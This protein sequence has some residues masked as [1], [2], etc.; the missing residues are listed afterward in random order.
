MAEQTPVANKVRCLW[1]LGRCR[2]AKPSTFRFR[3]LL[4]IA[5]RSRASV[6]TT[7]NTTKSMI[8]AKLLHQTFGCGISRD[9]GPNV[10]CATLVSTADARGGR[11]PRL[12]TA[13]WMRSPGR[14][15]GRGP[16][17]WGSGLGPGR[18]CRPARRRPRW[19]RDVKRGERRDHAQAQDPRGG[20]LPALRAQRF[21]WP[22]RW[23]FLHRLAVSVLHLPGRGRRPVRRA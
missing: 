17:Q 8:L 9:R 11:G 23:R 5:G 20:H 12:R 22:A 15:R 21:R 10:R 16:L 14:G 1:R 19:A 13:V 18:G 7:R 2:G 6:G 4:P 3:H